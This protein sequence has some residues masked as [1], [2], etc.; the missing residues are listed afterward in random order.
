MQSGDGGGRQGTTEEND[1]ND[2]RG[3]FGGDGHIHYLDCG[4]GFKDATYVKTSNHT[5]HT[6]IVYFMSSILQ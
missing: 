1:Y 4:D 3:D 6:H 2:A 5:F